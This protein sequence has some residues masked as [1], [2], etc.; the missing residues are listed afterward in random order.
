[1][2]AAGLPTLQAPGTFCLGSIRQ[3]EAG[4]RHTG[5]PKAKF[6]QRLPA[7]YGLSHAFGEFIEFVVHSFLFPLIVDYLQ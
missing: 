1:V 7:G 3:P 2:A 6:L 4:Q 5:Q